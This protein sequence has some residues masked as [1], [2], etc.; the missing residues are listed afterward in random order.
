MLTKEIRQQIEHFVHQSPRTVQEVAVA[1]DK[2]W[3]TADRYIKEICEEFGTIATKTF[4]EG[5]RGALKLV[6][7]NAIAGM[8]GTSFQERLKTLI[9]SGRSKYDFSPMDIYQFADPQKRSATIG[10]EKPHIEF[11]RLLENA[12]QQVL[13]FS[14][15]LSWINEDKK[16]LPIIESLIKRNIKIK[17][18]TRIDITSID[19]AQKLLKNNISHGDDI[20]GIRHCVQPLR[21]A[22][23]DDTLISIKEVYSP[24]RQVEIKEQTTINYFLRD[25]VWIY[26]LQKVFWH[27][28]EPSVDAQTRIDALKTIEKEKK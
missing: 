7:W 16:M 10:K 3:R 12:Q 4:R 14:G 28:W 24:E 15:N 21:G 1:I 11:R 18:L 17:I 26:W 9:E 19:T 5:S 20:T 2:N 6:Y 25:S 8:K 13:F 22:I 23:I 27:L